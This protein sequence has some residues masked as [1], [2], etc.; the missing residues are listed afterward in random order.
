MTS[1][2]QEGQRVAG[3]EDL[4]SL[5]TVIGYGL[6]SANLNG[7][8]RGLTMHRW[9]S[10]V[11]PGDL[12]LEVT[13]MLREDDRKRIGRLVR[14]EMEPIHTDKEWKRVSKDWEGQPRPM[15]R[16][17]YVSTLCDGSECRWTNAS[18]VRLPESIHQLWDAEK[19]VESPTT[20]GR[21]G[22]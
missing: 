4:I 13:S 16:V 7:T 22:E 21:E 2:T 3:K 15:E 19:G 18:F 11:S 6:Y 12:V 1:P 17:Y 5:L 8:G 9:H 10:Q 20:S 14:V